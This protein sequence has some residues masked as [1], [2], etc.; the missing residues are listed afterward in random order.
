MTESTL[1]VICEGGFLESQA[2][3]R[4]GSC[5]RSL[6]AVCEKLLGPAVEKKRRRLGV[7][8]ATAR[9]DELKE[10][11]RL[12]LERLQDGRCSGEHWWVARLLLGLR[13]C[14]LQIGQSYC[15]KMF[16]LRKL[17][18]WAGVGPRELHKYSPESIRQARQPENRPFHARG[19]G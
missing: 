2:L 19:W 10:S 18:V 13:F 8:I 9:L 14:H 12:D 16:S 11:E 6:Y 4:A 15:H 1:L 7:K 5:N 3:A 17:S